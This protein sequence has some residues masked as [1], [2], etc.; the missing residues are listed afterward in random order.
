MTKI[1]SYDHHEAPYQ[2]LRKEI[3]LSN[4]ILETYKGFYTTP[5]AGQCNVTT[6]NNSLLLEIG[7]QKLPIFPESESLFFVKERDLTFEL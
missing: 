4:K 3:Q 5:R 7:N 2:N 1:L 6:Q